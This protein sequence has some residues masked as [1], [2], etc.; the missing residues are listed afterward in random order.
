MTH[1]KF[2]QEKTLSMREHTISKEYTEY[3]L[4]NNEATV[5]TVSV[6]SHVSSLSHIRNITF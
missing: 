1:E 3:S 6:F 2:I 5:S 4:M